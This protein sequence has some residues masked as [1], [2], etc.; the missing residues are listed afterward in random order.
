[1]ITK[2]RFLHLFLYQ[3]LFLSASAQ[4]FL[5]TQGFNYG[6]VFSMQ[7]QPASVVD[8]RLMFDVGLGGF[9]TTMINN[10][11]SIDGKKMALGG[12]RPNGG[13]WQTSQF[14]RNLKND[15]KYYG[16]MNSDLYIPLLHFMITTTKKSGIGFQ[17]RLRSFTTLD[18]VDGYLLNNL[19]TK[20]R[21]PYYYGREID[22]DRTR[23]TQ[24]TFVDYAFTYGRILMDDGQNFLKMGATGKIMQ[25]LGASYGY[26]KDLKMT[27]TSDTTM[28]IRSADLRFGG[29]TNVDPVPNFSNPDSIG[30][31]LQT[32]YKASFPTGWGW[33]MG[34]VYEY[35]PNIADYEYEV[36]GK[37]GR[38]RYENKYKL[39][40][41][42]SV[43][44]LGYVTLKQKTQVIGL[45]GV[46][47]NDI[48]ISGVQTNSVG[49]ISNFF[50]GQQGAGLTEDRK[51]DVKFRMA[52]P[53]TLCFQADYRVNKKLYVNAIYTKSFK[54]NNWVRS[55]HGVSSLTITPRWEMNYVTSAIPITFDQNAGLN[56]G[57]AVSTSLLPI[58]KIEKFMPIHV[59][60]GSSNSLSAPFTKKVRGT[61]VYFGLHLCI[62]YRNNDIDFDGTINRKDKC[63]EQPGPKELKGC[64]DLDGDKVPDKDDE[65]P[66]TP[67]K[68]ALKGCPDIDND[69]VPD[70]KDECPTVK[71][72]PKLNGCPD[73]DGDQ[74]VDYKDDCPD[75]RGK[76]ELKGCPDRD[77]D[78]VPDAKDKCPT[79]KGSIA[80]EGCPDDDE[81][82]IV[83]EDDKC[84]K[85]KGSKASKGC[86]DDDEDGIVNKD[87]KC[88]TI[89]GKANTKGC[90]D[91][92][93][94]GIPDAEDDCPD[95]AG[96][97]NGKGCPKEEV[98]VVNDPNNPTNNNGTNDPK[99]PAN[100][101]IN[102][103][104]NPTNTGGVNDPKN[105]NNTNNTPSNPNDRDNDGI[106]NQKDLCPDLAGSFGNNGCPPS[107]EVPEFIK[108][109]FE[110]IEFDVA[111]WDIKLE[112]FDELD[113]LAYYLRLNPDINLYLKG[114]TDSDGSEKSNEALSIHR[115]EAVKEYLVAHGVPSNRLKTQGFGETRPKVANE[116]PENKQKNRRVEVEIWQ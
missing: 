73:R 116:S 81:D 40:L 106:V 105:P 42:A 50:S 80:A 9:S 63:V 98:I 83:N 76:K 93:N 69:N 87:D 68:I 74:V 35:R 5:G 71:G 48:N 2:K 77:N 114:N 60:F 18:N 41:G 61:D 53:T 85:E 65:C 39:R 20:N 36:N 70:A 55:I 72:S 64:P 27:F 10:Y 78:N 17:T 108:K 112:Y 1:M 26:A 44:D 24:T 97:K 94:D 32:L 11:L 62:P 104:K 45:A 95:K 79:V 115:A 111:K 51:E 47:K 13:N 58:P 82:G 46:D 22:A 99:N 88:P 3:L 25:G 96:D 101:G 113:G 67:G 89:A 12:T 33:D 52:L 14:Q 103:P 6:G 107:R 75:V 54:R 30:A 110:T 8:S 102:D 16:Y 37:K 91:A 66:S 7:T 4:N 84:P 21:N 109:A 86:P 19:Y 43:L 38:L 100:T 59:V 92:D 56:V 49:S 28:N 90:P 15:K 29:G 23:F 57:F 34:F 31:A